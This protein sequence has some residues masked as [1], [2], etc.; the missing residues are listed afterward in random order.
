[1]LTIRLRKLTNDEAVGRN[2]LVAATA[3]T[4]AYKGHEL[5]RRNDFPVVLEV[6]QPDGSWTEVPV[7]TE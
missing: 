5:V 7:V 6:M 4:E 3:R 1:M 2:T